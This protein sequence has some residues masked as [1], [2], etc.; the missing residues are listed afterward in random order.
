MKSIEIHQLIESL[1]NRSYNK[2][3]V[4][5]RAI[6]PTVDYINIWKSPQLNQ[7]H[8]APLRFY[9][10]KNKVNSY[11][12]AVLDMGENNLHW[13]VLPAYRKQGF[14]TQAMQTVILDH[15]FEDRE[16]Q[17]ITIDSVDRT[18]ILNSKRVAQL[19]GFLPCV[20][21]PYHNEYVLIYDRKDQVDQSQ[22]YRIGKK[23]IEELISRTQWIAVNLRLVHSE[24]SRAYGE[25]DSIDDLKYLSELIQTSAWTSVEE[26][27]KQFE[28][29]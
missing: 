12:A 20:D 13:Y 10:I 14:L 2:N 5:I 7:Y 21:S 1:N 16:K 17:Y 11:I 4:F 26:S 22:T 28:L 9:F 25:C 29:K 6:S 19:L 15:L 27:W 3:R 8:M 24:L 23:R 18:A